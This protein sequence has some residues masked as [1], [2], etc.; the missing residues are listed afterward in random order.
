[1][2]GLSRARMKAT[3]LVSLGAEELSAKEAKGQPGWL[4]HR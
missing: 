2:L 4:G 3:I 1:M